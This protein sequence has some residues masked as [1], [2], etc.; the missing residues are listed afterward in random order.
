MRKIIPMVL[1]GLMFTMMFT[2]CA[3]MYKSAAKS[4]KVSN[5]LPIHHNPEVGEYVVYRVVAQNP[6]QAA[7]MG[8]TTFT[9]EITKVSGNEVT[10]TITTKAGGMA[11]FMNGIVHEITTDLEGNTKRAFLIDGAE[12]T[13]LE[14]AK[15]GDDEYNTYDPISSEELA[16]YNISTDITVPAGTFSTS[17][18][19][20]NDKDTAKKENARGVYLGSKDV[21]FYQVATYVVSERDGKFTSRKVMELIKQG[22]R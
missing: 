13:K 2:S 14:I 9:Q 20:F 3:S 16:K 8:E 7:I 18:R 15:K 6:Q 4:T 5:G 11:S 22:K 17:A 19:T 21:I 1:I 10:F 12:R